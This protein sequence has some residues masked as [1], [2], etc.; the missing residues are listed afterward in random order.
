MNREGLFKPKHEF[1]Q[2]LD[3]IM[4]VLDDGVLQT[5]YAALHSFQEAKF[6]YPNT[7]QIRIGSPHHMDP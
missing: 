2:R 5:N 7:S 3:A 4:K 1:E 6:T